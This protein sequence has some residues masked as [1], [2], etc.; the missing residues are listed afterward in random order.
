ML[1]KFVKATSL[2]LLLAL[3]AAAET[4]IPKGTHITVRLESAISSGSARS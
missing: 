1:S 2:V 4:T 3:V